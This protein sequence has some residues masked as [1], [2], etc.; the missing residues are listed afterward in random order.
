MLCDIVSLDEIQN[1]AFGSVKTGRD[2]PRP[3]AAELDFK[4]GIEDA[5]T[6][7]APNY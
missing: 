5:E 4:A 7:H 1:R 6:G 2:L 3:L